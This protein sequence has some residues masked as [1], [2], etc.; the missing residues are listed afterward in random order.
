MKEDKDAR[1]EGEKVEKTRT[2]RKKKKHEGRKEGYKNE[3][4]DKE[5]MVIGH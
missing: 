1:E 3:G 4:K 2:K 5:R